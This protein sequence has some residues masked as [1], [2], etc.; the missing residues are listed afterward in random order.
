M[1]L[2]RALSRRDLT[3]AVS[4][5]ITFLGALPV[6]IAGSD[7]QKRLAAGLIRG[8]GKIAF[9]LTERTHG[10]DLLA[11]ELEAREDGDRLLI[12]GEKWLIGNATRSTAMTLFARTRAEGGPR[13]FS[14]LFADKRLLGSASFHH[15]PKVKTVGLR[16]AESERYLFRS[17]R[18]AGGRPH[19]TG[20]NG[21]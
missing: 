9:A 1:A 20:R 4:H 5:V 16:G 11:N 12:S 8:G 6:W 13:G 17:L 14:L 10:G 19:R 18:G 15:L 3:V 2:L 21:V 7:D